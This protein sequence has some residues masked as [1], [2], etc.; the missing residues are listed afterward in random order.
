[1]N[2]AKKSSIRIAL[3]VVLGL[4]LTSGMFLVALTTPVSATPLTIQVKQGSV[5][6]T[7][8]GNI[9]AGEWNDAQ[10]YSFYFIPT[11]AHPPGNIIVLLKYIGNTL[12][13]AYD[14]QPD[15][16]TET[17]DRGYILLDLN[18]NGTQDAYIYV[19]MDGDCNINFA[20]TDINATNMNWVWA[21]GN[22]TSAYNQ[23]MNHTQFEFAISIDRAT[24]YNNQDP[25]SMTSLPFG[26]NNIGILFSGYGTLTPDWFYGNSTTYSGG[27]NNNG[28]VASDFGNLVFLTSSP[29]PTLT[30]LDVVVIVVIIFGPTGAIIGLAFVVSRKQ[31]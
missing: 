29:P 2:Q 13:I 9:T 30:L 22:S 24:A 8:D 17:L 7:I 28:Q 18:N 12:Y 16:T 26:T 21:W 14:V 6:P 4:S 20:I 23:T 11:S 3:I 15:N 5:I 27:I 1:M 19:R 31:P 25:T 10:S